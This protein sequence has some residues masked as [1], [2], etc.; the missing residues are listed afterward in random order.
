MATPE[1]KL[2]QQTLSLVQGQEQTVNFGT[3]KDETGTPVDIDTGFTVSLQIIPVTAG[4]SDML[5]TQ[6]LLGNAAFTL[7]SAGEV[8]GVFPTTVAYWSGT[9]KYALFISNDSFATRAQ[10]RK[11]TLT[12]SPPF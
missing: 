8:V 2:E 4:A 3:A 1:F 5:G 9:Y 6:E 12:V 11:G 10:L 7:G